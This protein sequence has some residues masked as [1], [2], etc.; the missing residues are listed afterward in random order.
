M[1]IFDAT[2]QDLHN[3]QICSQHENYVTWRDA[4]VYVQTRA[5]NSMP[6]KKRHERFACFFCREFN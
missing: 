4:H 1:N 2:P 5:S 6:L 3:F